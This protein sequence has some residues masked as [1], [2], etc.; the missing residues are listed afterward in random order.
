MKVVTNKPGNPSYLV[1]IGQGVE[2]SSNMR[3]VD[4]VSKVKRLTI[5]FKTWKV[6]HNFIQPLWQ[7]LVPFSSFL[8]TIGKPFSAISAATKPS[9]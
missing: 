2:S 4:Q 1:I 5:M 8:D 6:V 3:S 9:P 7:G